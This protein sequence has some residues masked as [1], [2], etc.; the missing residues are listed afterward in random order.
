MTA[1]IFRGCRSLRPQ[2]RLIQQ[3]LE[4]ALQDGRSALEPYIQYPPGAPVN[5]WAKLN[6]SPAWSSYFLW[7]DGEKQSANCARCPQTTALL[8]SLPLAQMPG[9]APTAMFSVLSPHTHIP[10]HTGSAN[11]RL[12]VHLPLVL[13]PDCAF[14][15]GNDTRS[16]EM[17]QAWVLDDTIEHEAWNNSDETR[18]I[19]IFDV[20]NPLLSDA[21]RALVTE[22]LAA[23]RAYNA[24]DY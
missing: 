13:P 24:A 17:G 2:P 3:E 19:L 22:M 12:I 1:I 5:Q 18:V 16:W 8:D 20:W 21:E 10:P 11:T 9:Y 14:R 4:V 15:V 23:L 6:H 7:R